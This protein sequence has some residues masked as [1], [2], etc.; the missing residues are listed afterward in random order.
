MNGLM[1]RQVSC[2]AFREALQTLCQMHRDGI[3][4]LD[5]FTFPIALKAAC[6][7][8]STTLRHGQQIHA[9]VLHIGFQC[10]IYIAN[11][12][13]SMYCYCAHLRDATLVFD[14][15]PQRS[16]VTWNSI[17]GG[18]IRN[19]LPHASLSYFSN[20]SDDPDSVTMST[21]LHAHARLGAS[22]L[23]SGRAVHAHVLRWR[24]LA[25]YQQIA[26]QTS[27]KMKNPCCVVD[28]ALIHMYL[29]SSCLSYAEK[30]FQGMPL[31]N[32]DL[33]TWTTMM[34]GYIRSDLQ[35]LALAT[36][37]SMLEQQQ[38]QHQWSW[39]DVVVS[40]DSAMLATVMPAL[41]SLRHGKE[42]HCFAIKRD[43]DQSNV[44]VATSLL[45]M[46]AEFGS[47]DCAEKQFQRVE[48]KNVVAWTAMI[49]AYAKHGRCEDCFRLFGEMQLQGGVIPNHLTFMGV[50]TACTHAGLVEQAKDYFNCM[51]QD[52]GLTPD[53]YHYAAMVDM[54]GRAG[55]LKE[56]LK[57]IAAMPVEPTAPVWGS[58]MAACGLHHDMKL[59]H[60]VAKIVL[61]MEPEN[62]GNFVFLC[63]MLAQDQRWDDVSVVREAMKRRGLDKIP[64]YSSVHVSP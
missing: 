1:R 41:T 45:H 26:M 9:L 62:P 30:V 53:M 46:Y 20:M 42:M 33:V 6:S 5:H 57:F 28:N 40:L 16:T 60:E 36:F 22:A 27:I 25:C 11:A 29:E 64:G 52:Y 49:T 32:R 3:H 47:I 19:G 38:Q 7:S 48:E 17:M 59:G 61:D 54:L 55:R 18:C 50:L 10:D 51:T 4:Q 34:S 21:L 8:S 13:I 12:L 14:A 63:N 24:G 58:L 15:M 23:R 43:F 39:S 56:A 2:G 35:H 37:R 44:F 31:D